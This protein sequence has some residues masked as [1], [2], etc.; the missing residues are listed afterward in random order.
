M[1]ETKKD[2]LFKRLFGNKKADCCEIK[3]EENKEEISKEEMKLGLQSG[4]CKSDNKS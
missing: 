4:C 2:G 1:T 3:I